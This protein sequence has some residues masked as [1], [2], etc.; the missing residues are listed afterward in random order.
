MLS[1]AMRRRPSASSPRPTGDGP[2]RLRVAVLMGGVG[3]EREVSLTSGRAV[4]QALI[5]GG[6]EPRPFV[7]QTSDARELES[8]PE[9]DVVFV[10][11]HGEYGEDGRVQRALARLG[12][13]YTGSGPQASARAFDKA[14]T[15]RVLANAQVSLLP[16]R[17]LPT[18]WNEADLQG[19]VESCQEGTFVVKPARAGSSVGV[20]VCEGGH[21]VEEALREVAG[22]FAQPILIEPF[23]PGHELTCGVLGGEALPVVEIVPKDGH[24][25]YL[26]KYD[27]GSGTAYRIDP[28]EIPLEV[29][30]DIQ[31]QTLAAHH[32][33]GCQDVSRADF[34][35]DPTA[36]RA[37][38]LEVNTIPGMTS[39]SLL[40]KAANAIGL[41]FSSLV[42]RICRLSMCLDSRA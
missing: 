28:T 35:Y 36:G 17:L 42:E 11:L 5:E 1:T 21:E 7:V 33:L 9:V 38:L 3:H 23:V 24:Y 13:P 26:A 15:K 4:V 32:G 14:R 29:R 6:H 16:H 39:T 40:P 41:N 20:F 19:I 25:D 27:A 12:K 34:R 10:A 31:R 18:P 2:E 30:Q 22:T 8:L 37:T